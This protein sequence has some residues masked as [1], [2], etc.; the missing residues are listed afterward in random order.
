MTAGRTII[1]RRD[2]IESAGLTLPG[3]VD[4][5][6]SLDS[7]FYRDDPLDIGTLEQWL[8]I[9]ENHPDTWRALVR[10]RKVAGYWQVAPLAKSVFESVI[11]DPAAVR[12]LRTGD[13]RDLDRPGRCSLYVVSVCLDQTKRTP[14][15]RRALVASFMRVVADLAARGIVIDEVAA[16][17]HSEDGQR[18]CEALDMRTAENQMQTRP[19]YTGTLERVVRT[20][21][22]PL[23]GRKVMSR[24]AG[25]PAF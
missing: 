6:L 2:G 11:A 9:F 3:F 10:D 8:P 1:V 12:A 21:S 5:I 18:L 4:D 16:H 15:N 23:P 24:S 19:L 20:F 7:K 22:H 13:Y 14:A 25:V 17:V